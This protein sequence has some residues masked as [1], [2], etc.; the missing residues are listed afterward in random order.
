VIVDAGGYTGLSAAYFATKYPEATI[1]AIEPDAENFELLTMNTAR[2]RNVRPVR[3]AVWRESGMISLTDPGLGAVSF[4]VADP[5]SA[6]SAGELVRAVTIDEIIKEFGL[7]KIDL[8]KMDVEGSEREIFESAS[9]WIASVDTICI[10]LH[11][12]FK[13][14]CSRAFFGAV[15]EFPIELRRNEDVLV[16]RA[17]SRLAPTG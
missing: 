2:F 10:E 1:I 17:G 3:A 9:P 14:G 4:Q 15:G 7:E 12:R 11:D 13:S 5:N 6:G 16:S 8:L